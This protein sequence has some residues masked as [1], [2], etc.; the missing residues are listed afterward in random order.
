MNV[1]EIGAVVRAQGPVIVLATPCQ[2]QGRVRV[3]VRVR[4]RV[5]HTRT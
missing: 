1:E 2:G 4:A 3:R 5:K